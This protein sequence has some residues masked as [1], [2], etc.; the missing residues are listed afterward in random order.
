MAVRY[1]ICVWREILHDLQRWWL[2]QIGFWG[3]PGTP[4]PDV[5]APDGIPVLTVA[6]E[7]SR[8][9]YAAK[10][11]DGFGAPYEWVSPVAYHSA[12]QQIEELEAERDS[13]QDRLNYLAVG[14]AIVAVM[15]LFL[16]CFFVNRANKGSPYQPI[17]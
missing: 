4:P 3:A 6:T 2:E 9:A 8:E 7:S 5:L 12:L 11:P 15:G 14:T 1:S 17:P 10:Y 13:L 16:A